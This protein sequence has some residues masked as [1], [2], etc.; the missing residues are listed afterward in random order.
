MG[1]VS[2]RIDVVS[3]NAG[4]AKHRICAS[5]SM[6]AFLLG[7]AAGTSVLLGCAGEASSGDPA[8]ALRTAFPAHAAAILDSAP[9]PV[10]AEADGSTAIL[11]DEGR[12]ARLRA[13]FPADG[14]QPVRFHLPSGGSFEVREVGARGAATTAG[15][16]LAYA[17]QGG[18]SY[19]HRIAEGFEEWLLLEAGIAC[20]GA[21]AAAWEVTGAALQKRGEAIE[22]VVGPREAIVRVTAPRAFAAGGREV[23]ATLSVVGNRISIE[24]DAGCEA[25]L[26]DP[27]WVLTGDMVSA[28]SG[29]TVALLPDGRVLVMGGI[30]ETGF[31]T[32]AAETWDIATNTWSAAAPMLNARSGHASAVL[33]GGK[34]L[35]AGGSFNGSIALV[36]IYDPQTNV[37]TAAAPMQQARSLFSVTELV[38][39]RVLAAGGVA[40]PALSS[41]EIYDPAANTWSALPPMIASR[42][43]HTATRLLDGRV[44]IWGASGAPGFPTL[45]APYDLFDPA[46]NS[47]SSEFLEPTR[48]RHTATLLPDGRVLIAGGEI[49]GIP[50]AT[51]QIFDPA[52]NARNYTTP[53]LEERS[54]HTATL[55]TDGN[56]LVTGGYGAANGSSIT[57]SSTEIYYVGNDRWS[58]SAELNQKRYGHTATPLPDTRV[59]VTG[60]IALTQLSSS[61]I[62]GTALGDSCATVKD[63]PSGFCVDGVCCDKACDLGQ[64]DACSTAEGGP[65]NGECN[66]LTDAPCDDGLACTEGSTC[67]PAGAC[68]VGAPILCNPSGECV[69][70][71]CNPASGVC[72]EAP[73]DDG[74]HCSV[75]VCEGGVCE[76]LPDAGAGGGGGAGGA[77]GAGGG[78]PVVWDPIIVQGGGCSCTTPRGS[79]PHT[80]GWMAGALLGLALAARARGARK[81]FNGPRRRL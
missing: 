19:W 76:E 46:T 56:V 72:E 36:E 61:E 17:R 77:G 18:R 71:A 28:R 64:C 20:P 35:V 34:V 27:A 16:A 45:N 43:L 59:L 49:N 23:S 63:C 13:R 48:Q 44:L 60:G 3:G 75:G 26:V 74:A 9:A 70:S 30:D 79:Q 37:W 40:G 67:D 12:R 55:L 31:A 65:K 11:N 10:L 5:A 14:E 50:L 53:M 73:K 57:H 39:G 54:M 38:D 62:Y 22:V 4:V 47:W 81:G 78:E 29:H 7:L 6:A 32:N 2:D 8:E 58:Y 52:T 21:E 15:M 51:V 66:I 1:R 41:A 68:Q 42:H 69:K 80:Q 33:S 24:V 25:A